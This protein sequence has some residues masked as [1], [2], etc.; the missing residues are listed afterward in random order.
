MKLKKCLSIPF[1][2]FILVVEDSIKPQND[3]SLT[4]GCVLHEYDFLRSVLMHMLPDLE[5]L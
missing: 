5:T 3:R 1:T 2:L 4:Q